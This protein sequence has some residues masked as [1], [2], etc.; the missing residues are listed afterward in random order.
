M[1]MKGEMFE[2]VLVEAMIFTT[3]YYVVH[4]DVIRSKCG[5]CKQGRVTFFTPFSI[6]KLPF[7]LKK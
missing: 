4:G 3:F 6:L 2:K 5:V 7:E 1:M